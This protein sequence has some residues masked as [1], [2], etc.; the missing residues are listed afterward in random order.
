MEAGLPV[1]ECEA[2]VR[3]CFED[4]STA[5]IVMMALQPDNEPLPRGI[6]LSARMSGREVVFEVRSRRP[7]MSLLA[8]IDDILASAMLALKA[9]QSVGRP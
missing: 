6:E 1:I 7:I 2:R 8:T 5:E 3:M 4:S 9:L